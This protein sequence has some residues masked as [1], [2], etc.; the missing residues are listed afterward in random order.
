M[1][2]HRPTYGE[3]RQYVLAVR[4]HL[5]LAALMLIASTTAGYGYSALNPEF[6]AELTSELS[7]EFGALAEL[8]APLLMLR[9]FAQNS[10]LCFAALILGIILAII[11]ILFLIYNGF[12]I[13]AVIYTASQEH[14]VMLVLVNILPHGLIEIPMILLSV[15]IGI[16]LGQETVKKLLG[17]GNVKKE[18]I[19]GLEI[20]AFW[21]L[22]LLFIAAAIETAFII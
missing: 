22:P 2:K 20:Y 10:V 6:S 7:S 11:P 17:E 9:I 5:F 3:F 14:G 19:G 1:L 4:H 8:P 18:L 16:R 21:V 15:A 12:I 13:G